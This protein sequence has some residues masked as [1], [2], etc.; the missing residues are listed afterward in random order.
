MVKTLSSK[1]KVETVWPELVNKRIHQIDSHLKEIQFLNQGGSLVAKGSFKRQIKYV[2]SDGKFRKTEDKLQ[3]EVI[4]GAEYP[5]PLP[6][7]TT[8]LKTDYYIFQPRRLGESQALLEQGFTLIINEFDTINQESRPF[9]ILT[10][11][12]TA[13][14]K[15]ETVCSLPLKLK[16]DS[17]PKKFHG[18]IVFDRVKPPVATGRVSGVVI[19]RN[20]HNILKELE[21]DSSL[22]FLINPDQNASAGELVVNGTIAEVDWVPPSYGQGWK[23]ELRLNYDWELVNRKELPVLGEAEGGAGSDSR[24]K[25][26]ILIKKDFF[27]FPQFFK[28]EGR[29]EVGP[30]EV[31]PVI[32]RFNWKRVGS[33][34][35]IN[36]TVSFELYLPDSSGVEKRRSFDFEI[37][38]LVEN[39]FENHEDSRNLTLNF[40]SNLDLIKIN[41][42]QAFL[43]IE[44]ILKVTVKMYQSR[45]I[46][47]TCAN[48]GTEIISLTPAAENSFALLSETELNLTHPPWKVLKVRHHLSQI[49]PSLKKGWLNLDGV[50]EV[51][52]VYLD[53]SHQY[54][55][56]TF[57]LSFHKTYYWEGINDDQNYQVDLSPRLEYD[58]FKC[59][60]S[61]LIYKYLWHYATAAFVKRRVLAAVSTVEKRQTPQIPQSKPEKAFEDFSIQG[62]VQ[63]ELG[64][65]KEIAASRAL[66]TE[67]T[68]RNALNAILIEGRIGG[69]I[70]YW[71]GEGFLRREKLEFPFWTFLNRPR[72]AE[73]ES[74]LMPRLRRFSYSPLNPWP[75]RKG[76]IR[77]EVDIEINQNRNEGV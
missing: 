75:W 33:G 37:D 60:G 27:Q 21:V 32:K 18:Q 40:E 38:E 43:L 61:R 3:F 36:A 53:R 51:T 19:Y 44:A 71:D 35:S 69:E 39:F 65:P 59:E 17:R 45:V 1:F 74:I 67:F 11:V 64:N 12:V 68:W 57:H 14:G 50:S 23:M 58:S 62:E 31:E 52:V 10:D 72:F 16:K 63:L 56:E 55:E 26:D 5:E 66:I 47:L 73:R 77:Y 9:L 20:S 29:G 30:F 8:E 41:Y 24:I 42:D 22:S 25:A 2:D 54:R 15:G 4:M 34:L 76:A 28:A 49:N 70:E 13:K 6:F 7:F 48:A 46:S